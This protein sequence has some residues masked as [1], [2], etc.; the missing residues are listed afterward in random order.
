MKN[1]LARFINSLS[2]RGFLNWMPDSLLLKIIFRLRVGYKLDLKNPKSFNEKLQWLKINNRNPLYTQLVDKYEVRKYVAE[3]IGDECLIPLLGLWNNFD[4]IDFSMLPNQFVLK[5]TH[6][7][8]G[9]VICKDKSEFDYGAAKK[10]I[11]ESLKRNYY[12]TLREWPYKNVKPRIIAEKFMEVN[13]TVG[14]PD[15]KI[16]C[17]NGE[18]KIWFTVTNRSNGDPRCDYYDF[19]GDHLPFEQ[20]YKNSDT[21]IEPPSTLAQMRE[22][23]RKLTEGMP[24][25]RVDFYSVNNQVYFGELTFFDSSGMDPFEPREWDY[26]LGQMIR[27]GEV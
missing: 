11:N 12:W 17:F 26:K 13:P 24:Q 7:S 21:P 14:L 23:A 4:E 16:F 3:R 25:C 6:D 15:Y 10:K 19:D 2:F 5:C 20:G 9:V 27:L 22:Y 8:G 1:F 18:P